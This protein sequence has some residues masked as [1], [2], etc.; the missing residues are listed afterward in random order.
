MSSF[1]CLVLSVSG[2][3]EVRYALGHRLVD[4]YLEVNNHLP[5][6]GMVFADGA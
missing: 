2:S 5:L 6:R 4:R 3:G 1:P